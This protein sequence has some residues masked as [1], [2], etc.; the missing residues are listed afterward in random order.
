MS[1]ADRAAPR[2]IDIVI[3]AAI[4]E[5]GVI[6]R[7]NKLP[8]RLK[9]DMQFFRGVTMGK[10]VVM[11]RKT[12]ASIGKPL[13]GR[14]NIIISRDPDFQAPG[15]VVAATLAHALDAARGD[16]LRRGA[17]SIAVIGG[18]DIFTQT[19]PFADRLVLT[20]VHAAPRGDSVFPKIDPKAWREIK[21]R[22]H[23]K[24]PQDDCGFSIVIYVRAEA[25]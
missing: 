6:G 18:T 21:R 3:V 4:A 15:I 20:L 8:W 25:A 11:G 23:A 2:R 10:P 24:G 16:A 1:A 19:M 17:D 9:S 13:A 5:N 14:T 12:F 7:D 22:D